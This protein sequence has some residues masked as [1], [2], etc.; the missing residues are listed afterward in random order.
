MA[1]DLVK[2]KALE[3]WW[4]HLISNSWDRGCVADQPQRATCEEH[5]GKLKRFAHHLP[6]RL[7][8]AIAAI[9]DLLA[10]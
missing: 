8:F 5:V 10:N 1:G 9:R 4:C 7:G 3:F 6:L 2:S